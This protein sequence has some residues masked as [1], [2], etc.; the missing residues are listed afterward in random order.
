MVGSWGL[1]PQTSTVSRW[2]SNQLSYEPTVTES[3]SWAFWILSHLQ[4]GAQFGSQAGVNGAGIVNRNNSAWII[5]LFHHH[6]R[7]L[8]L[9]NLREWW[10][11][12]GDHQVLL[13]SLR[14]YE[15]PEDI[16][17]FALQFVSRTCQWR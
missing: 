10:R 5:K 17:G 2:R 16:L 11:V 7:L 4:L 13:S 3:I 6:Y 9:H 14:H 8:Q 1:E 12:V 15:T